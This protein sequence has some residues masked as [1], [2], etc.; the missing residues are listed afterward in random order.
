VSKINAEE[1]Q[2][3][4]K[5]LIII[6]VILIVVFSWFWYAR[7]ITGKETVFNNMIKNSLQTRGFTKIVKQSSAEGSVEQR[8][9]AQFG[10]NNLVEVVSDVSQGSD[11]KAIKVKT[12]TIA[13]PTELYVQYTDIKTPQQNG[14][15]LDFK[16][17]INVWGKQTKAEGG[18][19]VFTESVFGI[20]MFGNLS[21]SH[22]TELLKK[23]QD[24]QVYIVDY[25]KVKTSKIDGKVNYSYPVQIS[26]RAYIDLAKTYDKILGTKTLDN[27]NPD[28]YSG[29]ESIK[30]LVYVD[31][32]SATLSKIE[33]QGQQREEHYKGH[34]IAKE[35]G[36]PEQA[37]ALN[38][39][40]QKLTKTLEN[41]RKK[42]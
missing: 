19:T 42:Q 8:S 18:G 20:V 30:A 3:Y 25:S 26:A 12:R 32:Q 5:T 7:V 40:E 34:G 21:T 4:I 35:V 6:A 38:E 29:A 23:I 41:S 37:I 22:R 27:I 28:D 10:A 33:L 39:L 31:K 13:T 14:K 1:K 24:N 36:V 15:K 2:V 9:Q 16:S 17:L 11:N